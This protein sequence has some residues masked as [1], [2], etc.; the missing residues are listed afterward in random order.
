MAKIWYSVMGEGYGHATRSAPV[1]K[2]LCKNHDL[3]VTGFNKSYFYLKKKFPKLVH[4]IEGPGFIYNKNEVEIPAT[5][6][7]FIKTL[8]EKFQKNMFHCFNLIKKFNPDL[9]ISDF[10]PASSYFAYFLG[11]PIISLD[12]MSV[13]AKCKLNVKKED[14]ADYLSAV[15]V[16]NLFHPRVDYYLILTL[17]NFQ[18][19]DKNVFLFP[20]VLRKEIL[21]AKSIDGDFVLIYQTA[22]TNFTALIEDLKRI[23]EK[24][25]IYGTNEEKREGNL[26][27]KKF[28]NEGFIK[29][30]AS[31]KAIVMT[32][33]F[34]TISE[35]LHLKKPM[36]IVPAKNQFEQKFN[37]LTIEDMG[38][39]KCR[40]IIDKEKIEDFVSK[41]SFYRK[42]LEEI[43]PWEHSELT[44]KIEEL[45]KE[46][47][48]R[49]KPIFELAKKAEAFF[50]V[51]RY[52]RTLTIIKPDA[53]EKG[54]VGEVIKRLEKHDI[55]PV[56]IKMIKINS[57]QA[58]LFYKHLKNKVPESVFNSL[59]SYMT[60]NK[61]VLVVWQAN[62]VVK[63]VREICGPTNP[64]KAKKYNIRALSKEDM[65]KK[66]KMGK[67]VKNIIH[68]SATIEEAKK[69]ISFFFYP[70]E[71]YKP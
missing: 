50:R 70:W 22:Q 46:L 62:G 27:F 69:E 57:K 5:A 43:K 61:V 55:K 10:E 49:K 26:I 34:T 58:G 30:L 38:I 68:A 21:D 4:K 63:K 24:F 31:C 19:K 45:V 7:N 6:I 1:I 40:E 18:V 25:V 44:K 66:F 20:P 48:S 14:T 47:E 35:A 8:P 2:E 3:L 53:V 42:N 37:G 39:G 67:A 9:I 54:L 56:A 60:S 41:I 12:N 52:E 71:I 15:T 29:D 33:G 64:K 65:E 32:G 16:I 28:S 13:L 23:K 59:V 51:P 36:L 17:K 11:I